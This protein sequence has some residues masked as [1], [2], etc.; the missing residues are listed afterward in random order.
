MPAD[1]DLD[2]D[3]MTEEER[4]TKR[5][6]EAGFA[7]ETMPEPKTYEPDP[8]LPWASRVIIRTEVGSTAHGTGL[9]NKEDYDELGVMIQPW[10]EVVGIKPAT[11]TIVYRPG[12]AEGVR[13]EPGDYDLVVYGARK[14][15]SLAAKGNPS[16]LMLLFGP[17]RFATPL[18]LALRDLAPAFWSESARNRFLGY[19]RA[20]RERLL[21][22]RGGAHTNRPELVEQFGFDTKYAMH[23]LRLGF[24][25]MEY[26]RTGRLTLPIPGEQGDFLR[27]VR[28]GK[29]SL[30]EVIQRADAN[31]DTLK[32]MRSH[33]PIDPDWSA[34]NDWLLDVHLASLPQFSR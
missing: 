28:A 10:R 7:F 19:S 4:L 29:Y 6:Y 23:M 3:A 21:G 14:F 17:L 9:P 15:A 31:E 2:P 32:V 18:G 25:G 11:D 34:I 5:R 8:T 30:E 24:Q 26:V 16:I 13:S 27:D 20:Q 22:V 1:H 12:R 33:A